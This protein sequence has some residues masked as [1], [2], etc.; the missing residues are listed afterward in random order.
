MPGGGAI[1]LAAGASRR[2]GSDKRYHVLDDGAPL[3][4][5][6]VDTYVE[7]FE[8]LIV[9]LRPDDDALAAAL[10]ARHGLRSTLVRCPDAHLGMG[11]SLACGARAATRWDYVFVALGDMA[12][13]QPS[14]LTQLRTALEAAPDRIIQPVYE[15]APG[16]PVGFP[17]D[18]IGALTALTGDTGARSV[19]RAHAERIHRVAVDDPGVLQDLD[20]PL[21]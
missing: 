9:V 17:R 7:A 12:W 6:S 13:V 10:A 3:L 16:H 8:R 20:V 19:L 1:L 14:T 2:F 11:H 15:D 21:P 18:L 5:R 4:L